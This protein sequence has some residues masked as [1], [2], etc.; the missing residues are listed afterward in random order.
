MSIVDRAEDTSGRSDA[1]VQPGDVRVMVYR[2]GTLNQDVSVE[3]ISDLIGDPAALIWVDVFRPSRERLAALSAE[4][5]LHPLAVADLARSHQRPKMD[6]YENQSLVVLFGAR[7]THSDELMRD[8]VDIFTG[9]NFVLTVH[10]APLPA[11]ARFRA[12]WMEEPAIVEPSPCAFLVYRLADEIISDYFPVVDRL[13]ERLDMAEDRL[14]SSFD[15]HFLRSVMGLRRDLIELRRTLGPQRDVF[16]ALA[17]HDTVGVAESAA[18]FSD[19]VDLVLRVTDTV[20][21]MRDRLAAA[22]ESYLTLQ[23]N[24]LNVTMK[25][26]TAITVVVQV[27]LIIAGIYGMNFQHMPELEWELGYPLAVLLMLVTA[28]ASM[29]LFKVKDW[30]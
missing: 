26:L 4:F 12:R 24:S 10:T 19:L 15:R 7:F 20:D 27:P 11:L 6:Q 5:A 17:R 18:Y 1:A 30:L 14:F 9:R 29:A 23:S 8:E 2:A 22:L 3:Q 13:E 16:T 25:R 21:T 28:V